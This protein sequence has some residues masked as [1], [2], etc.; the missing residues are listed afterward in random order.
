MLIKEMRVEFNKYKLLLTAAVGAAPSTI[1]RAYD[2]P[3]IASNLDFIHVM[4][5]DY[6][7]SWDGI[8]GH[9]APLRLPITNSSSVA[10]E[11]R[12]SV[13]DTV[14]YLIKLGAPPHKLVLGLAFYGRTFIL[15]DENL[16]HKGA[17][18]HGSGFQGP[19]T[20]ED[21]FLGFNE[22]CKELLATENDKWTQEWD[23]V[24]EVPYMFKGNRWVSFDNEHSIA[25]K[26]RFA[27]NEKLAGVMIWAI[28][29]DDFGAE[30]STS[31]YPLLT[32]IHSEFK[33]A[34]DGIPD[35]T[36]N[37]KGSA[38]ILY[39]SNLYA[40]LLIFVITLLF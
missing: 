22:I 37:Q 38:S 20:R 2:I 31:K 23:D 34:T 16:R 33:A 3:N 10:P 27:F 4:T 21:G 24:A 15:Q 18:T 17:M 1:N 36:P 25:I 14:R 30:C 11:L 13:E 32:T 29:N 39:S 40:Y 7:G 26:T 19:Y 8:T 35:S 9:N 12:L 6:G 5:Y 28:D